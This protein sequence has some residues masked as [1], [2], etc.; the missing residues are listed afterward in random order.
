MSG[1]L[2]SMEGAVS[3]GIIWGIMVLG[4]YITYKILDIADLTV[5]GSFALGSVVCA[6]LI[7]KYD[8]NPLLAALL[9]GAA[10]MAAGAV[11]GF[12]HTVCGIPAILAGILTQLGLWSVNLRILDGASNMPILK[13]DTIFSVWVDKTG[14]NQATV[15]LILGLL[16]AAA[17]ILLLCW[18]F[19]ADAYDQQRS[20]RTLR[21]P[22]G[23]DEQLR[24]YQQRCG[25]HRSGAGG[26]CDRRSSYGQT[27]FLWKQTVFGCGGLCPLLCDPCRCAPSWH[28]SQRYETVFRR[29]CGGCAERSRS[30][31]EVEDEAVICG[32]GR[33]NAGINKC[34][35]NI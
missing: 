26:H 3:Q 16:I 13:K 27:D 34:E 22:G 9:A 35:K 31:A 18:F 1:F 21:R 8:M 2:V 23:S 33:V 20:G 12:L 5:D 29:L 32:G 17:V 14:M 24:R 28:E 7:V 25:S 10:G 11:T 15:V 30:D 19:G 4:V 6:L